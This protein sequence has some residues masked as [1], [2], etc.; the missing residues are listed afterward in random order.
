MKKFV[1]FRGLS[2]VVQNIQSVDDGESVVGR[3]ASMEEEGNLGN[4]QAR[5]AVQ[6]RANRARLENPPP[7]KNNCRMEIRKR[8][9]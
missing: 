8:L 7:K 3:T 2:D 4:F 9:K 6:E 1:E 5:L